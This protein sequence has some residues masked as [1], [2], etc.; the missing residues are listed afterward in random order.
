[1]SNFYDCYEKEREEEHTLPYTEPLISM[2]EHCRG[3]FY[4][5]ISGIIDYLAV[6]INALTNYFH[7]NEKI[8]TLSI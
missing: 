3:K 5:L 6:N 2:I 4:Q 8:Y 7:N 1:M